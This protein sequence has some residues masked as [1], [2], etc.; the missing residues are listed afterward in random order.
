MLLTQ[1]P[2]VRFPVLLNFFRGNIIDVAEVNQRCWLE[3]SGQW[4][5]NVDPT[6]L[7]LAS[8]KPV[9][10]KALLANQI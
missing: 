4:H 1:Q 5:E 2:R 6:R 7:V 10:Q 9:S 8:D 3:E